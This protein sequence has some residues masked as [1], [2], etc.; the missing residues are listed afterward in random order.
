VIAGTCAEYDWTAGRCSERETPTA[1]QSVYGV[2][3]NAT[4]LLAQAYA[5]ATGT[6]LAW[7]RIFHLYGPHEPPAR[8]V[9]S[10]ARAL[11]QGHDAQCSDPRKQ[12]DFLHVE[13]VAAAFV[14]LLDSTVEGPVNIASGEAVSLQTL[15]DA[16]AAQ[17]PSA[18]RVRFGEK[19]SPAG[20][21]AVLTADARRLREEVG[22]RPKYNLHSGIEHTM[23]W[24]RDGAKP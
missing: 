14:G 24:W 10:I 12:R 2:C 11:L 19:P 22:W 8:L 1:P 18:G 13:D 20:D 3:K 5:T 17:L 7:G 23:R 9:P 15:A 4:R 21:P 16:I 6:S